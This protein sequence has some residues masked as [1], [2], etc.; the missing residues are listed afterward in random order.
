MNTIPL[1]KPSYGPEELEALKAP[2]ESGWIGL[3][4]KTKEFE[5]AFKEY[6]KSEHAIG[7]SSATAALHLG[8]SMFDIKDREVI[9]T[10]MTFVSTNHA[11]LYGQ[12]IP[13]FADIEPDTLNIDVKEIE[14][15]ITP[16]TKAIVG[17]DYGGHPCDWDAINA[18]AKK[19]NLLVLDDAA[20]ACGSRYKD[21]PVGSLADITAFSFHAVKNLATGEGG[22]VTTNNPEWDK[23]IRSKR[24]MGINKSTFDRDIVGQG[25]SWYYEV[26]ELG[27][28]YHMSD[29][30]AVLGLVQLKKLDEKN[31]R[32]REIAAIYKKEFQSLAWMELPVEKPYAYSSTHNFVVKVPSE[33]R[34]K[35][36]SYL[37]EKGI[38]TGVH[39]IPN[40]LYKMYQP[41]SRKLP[42]TETVWKKIVTLPLF[43]DLKAEEIEYIIEAIKNFPI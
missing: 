26:E 23:R 40:H 11:I 29:I 21:L 30:A 10:S 31:K 33:S 34:D 22:M 5:D 14:K 28:K 37:K 24:W 7:T 27:W 4:P 19:H 25:Y 35:F 16:K 3:G 42:V 43:P 18:L 36:I 12:G 13:V 39:Y 20:H 17:V 1:F 6:V 2:F 9:T 41:Y 32:R 8:L 15:L 38:S